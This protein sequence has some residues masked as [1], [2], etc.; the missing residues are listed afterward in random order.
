MEQKHY[1]K[2][3]VMEVIYEMDSNIAG[4]CNNISSNHSD[5]FN[6]TY[7]DNGLTVFLIGC[8]WDVEEDDYCYHVPVAGN[9][10]FSS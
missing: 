1:E 10:V 5:P 3:D 9:V 2:P 4:T 6:C 7:D 8:G